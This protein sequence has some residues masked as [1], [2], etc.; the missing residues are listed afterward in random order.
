MTKTLVAY[1][2]ASGVTEAKAVDVAKALGADLFKI[3]PAHKYTRED[4]D[5]TNNRSRSTVEMQDKT[6]RPEIAEKKDNINSY[7]KVI[8]GFPVWWYTA[9]KIIN[10]FIESYDLTGK[11]LF[12]FAT[13]GG[14]GIEKCLEDLKRQYP[15]L[16]FE[17]G[18]LLNRN[19]S[20]EA[21]I[22]A[23]A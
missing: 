8:V 7:D 15:T 16:N 19:L 21:I 4:L 2:S 3:C 22:K 14:S 6:C 12:L 5:W 23:F 10:T 18:L 17:G 11:S 13:S 1:F 20:N 9:P